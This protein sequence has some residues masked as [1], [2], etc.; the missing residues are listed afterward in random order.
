[1][2]MLSTL[3]PTRGLRPQERKLRLD[4]RRVSY[5]FI[6]KKGG[7]LS[8]KRPVFS[9]LKDVPAWSMWE[10]D[11][12]KGRKAGLAVGSLTC[13][14]HLSLPGTPASPALGCLNAF[15]LLWGFLLHHVLALPSFLSTGH[16]TGLSVGAAA[17]Q[18]MGLL[19]LV[20][21]AVTD[22]QGWPSWSRVS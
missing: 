22:L 15:S 1:M 6:S 4:R 16:K 9:R 10:W 13:S 12:N 19:A 18:L 7:S 2:R 21:F 11:R 14:R 3:N 8:L 5:W 17:H 20:G